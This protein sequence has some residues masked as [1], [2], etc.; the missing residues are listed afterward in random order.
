MLWG[1]DLWPLALTAFAASLLGFWFVIFLS[2]LYKSIALAADLASLSFS[3]SAF[4]THLGCFSAHS[5]KSS[6]SLICSKSGCIDNNSASAFSFDASTR[7]SSYFFI[8]SSIPLDCSL[9]FLIAIDYTIAAT[10]GYSFA[11]VSNSSSV[12]GNFISF[13]VASPSCLSR[14][15]ILSSKTFFCCCW[16]FR[17]SP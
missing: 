4:C 1:S 11:Q 5:W 17:K 9:A 3:Y 7:K 14:F 2:A 6:V 15:V 10:S 12:L 8:L 13:L 16:C